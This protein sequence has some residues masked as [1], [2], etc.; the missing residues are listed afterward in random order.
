MYFIKWAT[1]N[2]PA[3]KWGTKKN[4][5]KSQLEQSSVPNENQSGCL[6]NTC[7]NCEYYCPMYRYAHSDFLNEVF[8]PNTYN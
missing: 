8:Y 2:A 3:F 6:P 5:E 1:N 7:Q 4:H